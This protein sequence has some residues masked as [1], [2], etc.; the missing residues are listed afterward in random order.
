MSRNFPDCPGTFQTVWKLA[1]LSGNFP[2]SPV[3]F[4]TVW[5]ISGLSGNIP[6]CPETFQAVWKLARL[7][8]NFPD[9]PETFRT[10]PKVSRISLL[11]HMCRESY[12]RT[13]G[14]FLLR[15][16]FTHFWCI[17]FVAKASYAL[18]AHFC[19]KTIYA[20]RPESFCA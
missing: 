5:K 11:T 16:L 18:L 19:R 20:L 15:K 13:F 10:V 3:S 7:S 17:F 6:D 9:S 14:V 12:F 4:E 1:R 8:G 2:D